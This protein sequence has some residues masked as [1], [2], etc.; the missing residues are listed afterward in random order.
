MVALT[1]QVQI[2]TCTMENARQTDVT[3]AHRNLCMT[4]TSLAE[5]LH[6]LQFS[7]QLASQPEV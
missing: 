2:D 4:D 6:R 3:P 5:K 1:Y 7:S